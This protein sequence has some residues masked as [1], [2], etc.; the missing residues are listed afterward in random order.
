MASDGMSPASLYAILTA[1]LVSF[2]VAAAALSYCRRSTGPAHTLALVGMTPLIPSRLGTIVLAVLR[3][4]FC[5]VLVVVSARSIT[6]SPDLTYFTIWNLLL[7]TA[8][9]GIAALAGV[10]LLVRGP[11]GAGEHWGARIV[12]RGFC[13]CVPCSVYVSL[14]TWCVLLPQAVQSGNSALVAV[15]V[16]PLSWFQHLANTCLLLVDFCANSMLIHSSAVVFLVGWIVAYVV[17]S[18][19]SFAV[20]GYW[21]YFFLVLSSNTPVVYFGFAMLAVLLFGLA[22]CASALKQWLLGARL[23]VHAKT[24]VLHEAPVGPAS[25]EVFGSL[26]PTMVNERPWR[27]H[28][29]I[30]TH[31]H[32]EV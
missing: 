24:H 2:L 21:P 7:Q 10:V 9:F 25:R 6:R 13:V 20:L 30:S 1:E 5:A 12:Y 22:M 3:G 8:Y 32:S 31:S 4:G 26:V 23:D 29:T 27:E 19:V 11:G 18:W 28:E 14:V 15:L 16:G 17:S